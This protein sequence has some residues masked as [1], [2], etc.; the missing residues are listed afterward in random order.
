MP[1]TKAFDLQEKR[2][3]IRISFEIIKKHV[4]ELLSNGKFSLENLDVSLKRSTGKTLNEPIEEKTEQCRQE[5]RIGTMISFQS[6]LGNVV[7]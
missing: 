7:K 6:T 2:E 5:G 1:T 3:E 4:V